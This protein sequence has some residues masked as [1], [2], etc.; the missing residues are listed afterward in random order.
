MRN[1]NL[2]SSQARSTEE[3]LLNQLK[4]T[5]LDP[6]ALELANQVE[7][8]ELPGLSQKSSDLFP[9]AVCGQ[10]SP[11]LLLHG[12]D[13]S[14]LEYR[15]L[16]PLLKNHHQLIIPDLFGFGFCPRPNNLKY[17]PSLLISHLTKILAKIPNSSPVGLIGASMG[18]ALAMELARQQTNKI[19]RL[20]LLSPAGLTGEAKPIPKPLDKIGV[21]FL[22]QPLIRQ[23]LCKQAFSN[24]GKSVGPAEKQ[25]A[26]LHLKV[27]G[28]GKSLASFARSGGLANCGFPLP[29]QPCNVL[30]GTNDRILKNEEKK[31]TISL[32]GEE[33]EELK[34][35]GHLPHL[36][37]PEVVASRWL[38]RNATNE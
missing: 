14:F 29:S 5:L 30:W 10:G 35:C 26:S 31:A 2:V 1:K 32:V 18:G 12:F 23:G 25:I 28:W 36:D 13:S 15:R 16:V 17:G 21:W 20:L 3:L 7:W 11:I 37:R 6:L 27:P 19:N 33:F 34:D 24:P 4:L 38:Q 8:W 22:S 9:V